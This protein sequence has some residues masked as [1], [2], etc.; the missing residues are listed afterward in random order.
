VTGS[1][2]E[3]PLAQE[4]VAGAGLPEDALLAGRTDLFELA[5]LVA[6]AARVVCGDTGV[7][8]LAT[9]FGVPSV[10]LFGPVS[11]A[12]WGPPASDLH[13]AL[14]AGRVGDAHASEPD[15]GLLEIGVQDVLAALDDVGREREAA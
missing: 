12:L 1:P 6:S 14:W 9:A 3:R 11:P 8:H 5:R 13:I 15:P 4:V 10:V 7:A 2:E